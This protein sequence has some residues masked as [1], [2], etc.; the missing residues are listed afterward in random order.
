[1]IVILDYGMG[2]TASIF[3]MIHHVGG[4]AVISSDRQQILDADALIL[5]GVGAF[6]NAMQ[7][8][9][10]SGL[11]DVLKQRVVEDEVPFLGICLGMQ[12]LFDS[13]EEGIL[14]GLGFIPG[15][16]RR[17]DF[18][19]LNQHQLKIPHMGWNVVKPKD[20]KLLFN[21]YE[22]DPRFYFVHSYH[23]VCADSNHVAATC[24]YGYPFTCAV[25][26]NNV[27]ATQFHPE[28]SHKFGMRLF[29]NFLEHLC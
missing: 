26:K 5:P 4:E 1:M 8:L 29:K 24:E 9:N 25:K 19:K 27:F 20:G 15:E 23:A 18:S 3:N 10:D 21:G 17:F 13:S 2:N 28:K 16:V 12:L 7:K 14:P 11:V 6:D 22:Q